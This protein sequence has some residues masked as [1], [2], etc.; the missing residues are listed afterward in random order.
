MTNAEG[1]ALNPRRLVW[2]II[3]LPLVLA[4][5]YYGLFAA[6]RYVSESII[7]V[8]ETGDSGTTT[9]GLALLVT[10]ANPPSRTETLYL[11]DYIHSM[12]MLKHLDRTL[13]LRAA[14]SVA[15]FDLFYHLFDWTSQEWFLE[16][17]RSRV[18][19]LL[20]DR[21]SLLTVR[22]EAFDSEFAHV[23]AT[24][25]LS[26]SER[27]VNEISHRMA[28]EQVAFAER[29]L[30]KARERYQQAKARL[31]EFQNR[32]NLLDPVAQAQATV[33]LTSQLEAEIA[34]LEAD[35]KN[36]LTYLKD[37]AHEVV[38]MRNKVGTLREQLEIERAKSVSQEGN[39]IN[40]L[41]A[42][43]QTLSIDVGFAEDAYKIALSTVENARIEAS[44][45]LK[46]IVVV[47]SPTLPDIAIYP[48][49][50]YNLLTLAIAL[51]LLYGIVRLAI[52]TVRDHQ[53]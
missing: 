31:I 29:E 33:S 44:R 25:I 19:V 24:E 11:I 53:D 7:T 51:T 20:D 12:D 47:E 41:A 40:T 23:L 21:S 32:H 5:C 45:K 37:S 28:R 16:Y 13:Q 43:F 2:V 9:S 27:F 42:E 3:V 26:Q 46:S 17:F 22:V 36:L 4:I 30:Q 38:S 18:E 15:P 14:Y 52:A 48:R 34:R 8:R 35:L 1:D 6:D 10:G 49:R 39:R 50:L